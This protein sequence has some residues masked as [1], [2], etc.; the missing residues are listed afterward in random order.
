MNG[1]RFAWWPL[2]RRKGRLSQGP[3]AALFQGLRI[4]LTLW[5][6]LVL[7]AALVLFCVVLYFGARYFLLNPVEASAEMHA[8][9]H[10][11]D[12]LTGSHDRACSS[13]FSPGR[14]G[15]PPPDQGVPQSEMV[16]CFDQNGTLQQNANTANLPPAFLSNTLAK[17]ALQAG[18][19][20]DTI[21][22]GGTV[23]Q[24]YRYAVAVPNPTGNGYVG[25]VLIGE[26]IQA[27]ES[28]LSLLLVLLLTIGGMTLLGAGL[29]GLFLADRAL[30][31]ARLAWTNQQRFIADAAHELR[32][33]LTLLRA[34]AEVL[35]R[36]REQL[37]TEDAALLEDIVTEAN[38]MSTLATNMLTLARLDNNSTHREHEVVNLTDVALAG[39]R[40]VQA[41]A[42]QKGIG[43]QVE[44]N[45]PALVIG[46]STLLEQGVLALLDNAIKYNR[47]GGRVAVG[48]AI[49]DKYALLEVSDSGIGIAAEHLPHLGE[50]FY[51]VDKSRSREA[52]G[53]GLGL[54]I[55]RSIAVVHG[56]TLTLTSVPEQ[57]TTVTIK[58]P[59]AHG[60]PSDRIVDAA[61]S[62]L[63]LP[64]KKM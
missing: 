62:V 38:H 55:A 54:S 60:T 64:E 24:I 11:V 59:L 22:G 19:A 17:T 43:V 36:S 21:D 57:G 47:P 46:D 3:E 1:S 48:T 49:Q 44:S 6:S 58:L 5:Y 27:Q 15:P 25:V 51:R 31:P 26:F 63:T 56:G 16:A 39:A 42:D 35:L 28:A 14:F 8:R 32:T 53:T 13:F 40:R 61:E 50:R 4:R 52:G 29:G 18:W 41:L 7:G 20:Y 34:D 30:V 37:A 2:W 23:G 9:G 33:P 12:W 45:D 10:A